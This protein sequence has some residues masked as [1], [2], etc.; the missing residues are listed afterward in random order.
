MRRSV[1]V[2]PQGGLRFHDPWGNHVE[3]VDYREVQF[4]KLPAALEW[5]VPGGLAKSESAL[6]ELA[7]RLPARRAARPPVISRRS[8]GPKRSWSRGPACLRRS[9]ALSRPPAVNGR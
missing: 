8:G 4:T 2:A 6:Q 1:D 7:S 3:I 5:L 9:A